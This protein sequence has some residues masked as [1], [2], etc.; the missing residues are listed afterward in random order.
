M[1]RT[2]AYDTLNEK[3]LTLGLQ[4]EKRW[5]LLDILSDFVKEIIDDKLDNE[6]NRGDY[7]RYD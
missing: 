6:F 3:L 2:P 4:D 1:S 7:R 5:E